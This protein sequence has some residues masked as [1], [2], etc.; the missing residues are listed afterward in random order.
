VGLLA[1]IFGP[2]TVRS[3]EGQ[4]RPGPWLTSAGWLGANYAWNWW[5]QGYDPVCF[6]EKLA[7]IEACVS[8]YAQTIAMCPGDHWRQTGNNGRERVTNSALSRILRQP[9]GYQSASDFLLNLVRG[10]MSNGNA[11][12]LAIRNNRFEVQ[13]LHLMSSTAVSPRFRIAERFSIFLPA[14][15]IIEAALRA[16]GTP[17]GLVPARDVLHVRLHTPRHPLLGESPLANAAMDV[18]MAGMMSSQQIAFYGNQGRPGAVL[19]TDQI[20]NQEQ[21][22]QL[23]DRWDE[24]S[25]GLNAGKMP[26]LSSGLKVQPW[27]GSAKDAEFAEV[28]KLTTANI[29]LA[30]RV[31]LQILGIGGGAMGSTEALMQLWLGSGSWLCDQ[32]RR[33]GLRSA[34][35][36]CWGASGI[37][38]I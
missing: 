7:I 13:E 6:G 17:L 24:Q 33:A 30:Y 25:Q 19:T 8:A 5:Q 16:R 29:A 4:P 36:A 20:L 3:V 26:I 15:P 28:M 37:H 34:V 23:R 27:A 21:A 22:Q 35:R 2:S 18:Q 31:P 14:I 1:R 9:N 10:T 38:R 11:Y 12:A 32:P